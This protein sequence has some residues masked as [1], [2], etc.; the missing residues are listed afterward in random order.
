MTP[1]D[2]FA[3]AR[4]RARIRRGR[5]AAVG[6]LGDHD[7]RLGLGAAAIVKA[8]AIGQR[9]VRTVRERGRRAASQMPKTKRARRSSAPVATFR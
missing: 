5:V 8:P 2:G 7:L 6:Q 3:V 1:V 9:S 4:D